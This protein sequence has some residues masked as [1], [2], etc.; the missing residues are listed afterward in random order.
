[1]SRSIRARVARLEGE[2]VV[3]PDAAR[4]WEV[5]GAATRPGWT[6]R[7]GGC[8]PSCVPARTSRTWSRSGCGPH[9]GGPGTR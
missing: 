4:F 7:G 9:S 2:R 6:R 3:V 5:V 1:M 8:W